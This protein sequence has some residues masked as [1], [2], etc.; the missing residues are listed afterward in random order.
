MSSPATL[1]LVIEAL[2]VGGAERVV[3]SLANRLDRERWQ[4]HVVCLREAGA[5]ASELVDVPL[6]VLDKRP[7]LDHQLIR[8]LR[9]LA[10]EHPPAVVNSH[11]WTANVWSCL[12]LRHRV[13]V[14]PT[15]HN[16]D[17][18]KPWHYRFIDRYLAWAIPAWVAVS[19]DAADFYCHSVALPAERMHVI[20]NG[21]D[22]DALSGGDRLATRKKLGLPED[23]LVVGTV[24]RLVP[25]KNVSRLL[26][27]F[28]RVRDAVPE[29]RLLLVGDGPER[30]ALER[31]AR[32]NDT[33][34]A[35]CFVGERHDVPDC[36]AAMDLFCLAS[37]REGHP[38][39]ALEAQAAGLP[40]VLTDVGGSS[41]ALA[42]DG[43]TTGGV[44]VLP[45][46]DVLAEALIR[47]LSDKVARRAHAEVARRVA[48]ER[49]GL[50]PMVEAYDALFR[51]VAAGHA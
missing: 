16:R 27:A 9:S 21:V 17:T 26:S 4:P 23:A 35:V 8:K 34:E 30:D 38:L 46:D 18:W 2:T 6:H 7:G 11:L 50:A 14:I 45:Q 51:S 47:L 40:V 22:V 24:G 36:L 39:T 15:Q 25:Q 19:E 44:L 10:A 48:H 41:E 3:V 32:G 5:L 28:A 29:A 13:P 1:W 20:R 49:F 43:A 33:R 31:Q 12:A 42:R 37:D